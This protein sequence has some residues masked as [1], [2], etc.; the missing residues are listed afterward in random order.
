M[1]KTQ[2]MGIL[3]VTP[4]SFSDGGLFLDVDKAVARGVRIVEEGADIVDIGGESS[5]PGSEPVTLEEEMKRVLPVIEKLVKEIDVPISIDTYKPEVAQAA[6]AAGAKMVND[7]SGLRNNGMMQVIAEHGIPVVIMHIQ[8][9]PKTMQESPQYE[10]VVE[11]IKGFFRNRIEEAQKAGIK[12][13]I[14]DPGIGFGKTLEHNL[15]ILRQLA[16]FK[17]LGYPILVG[18]S[19]KSFIGTITGL[20]V[21]DRLE[22]TIAACVMS[23]MNGASVVRVHDVK[24]CHRALQVVDAVLS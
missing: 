14:I 7:I 13:I 17:E 19:R 11:D 24:E 12:D 21:D 3:N 22:G 18:P 10:N 6:L 23:A 4:D 16:D 20:E 9:E 15:E 8:G 1:R 2:I 5:R